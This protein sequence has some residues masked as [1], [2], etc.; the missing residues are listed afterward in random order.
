M[1]HLHPRNARARRAAVTATACF[2]ILILGA[3]AP[4]MA[5]T[6]GQVLA[7]GDIPTVI[8]NLRTWL[9]GILATVATLFLTLGGVRYV[10]SGGNPGEIEKA[11]SAF[12]SAA[13]GYA[14]AVLAPVFMTILQSVVG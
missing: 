8:G 4:A 14:L 10:I 6:H 5:D 3:A 12:K 11:K 9:I 13:V 7:V 2:S 1:R